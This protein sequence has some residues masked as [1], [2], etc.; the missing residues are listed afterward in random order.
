M[1]CVH[2]FLDL[3]VDVGANIFLMPGLGVEAW[4]LNFM[5]GGRESRGSG[6]KENSRQ[7][8]SIWKFILESKLVFI[9]I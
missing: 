8:Y 7:K 2:N 4:S 5:R 1:I 6:D 9:Y 3:M